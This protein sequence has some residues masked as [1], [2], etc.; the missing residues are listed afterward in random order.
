MVH[1]CS[2][3]QRFGAGTILYNQWCTHVLG[4][5]GLVLRLYNQ[6][7]THV[8]GYRGLVLR[9]YNQWYTHALGYRGLLLQLYYLTNGALMPLDTEACCS[10]CTI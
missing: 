6:W 4:Y 5:R 9:Q 3:I 10:N 1:S 2:W 7:Y 8:L